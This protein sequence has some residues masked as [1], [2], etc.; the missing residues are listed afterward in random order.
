MVIHYT[1]A[2]PDFQESGLT[3]LGFFGQLRRKGGKQGS[4]AA[5]SNNNNHP[6][7]LGNTVEGQSS[8]YRRR[9]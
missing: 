1:L 6:V 5:R 4:A 3:F 7:G 2:R 9:S 8:A